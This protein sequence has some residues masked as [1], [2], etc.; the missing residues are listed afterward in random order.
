MNRN[1]KIN[2]FVNKWIKAGKTVQ[3]QWP[4]FA[5]K[6]LEGMLEDEFQEGRETAFNEAKRNHDEMDESE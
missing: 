4:F 5:K 2:E 6:E 3:S 1:D